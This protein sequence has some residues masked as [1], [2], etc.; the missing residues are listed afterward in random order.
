FASYDKFFL[1]GDSITQESY[2]QQWGFGFSAALQNAYIRRL[3]VVNRGLSGYNTRQALKVLPSIIPPPGQARIRFLVVFFGANDASVPWGDNKQHIPLDEY[4]DNLKNIITH[5]QVAAHNARIILV[6]PPPVNEHR[7]DPVNRLASD[8][9]KYAEAACEVGQEL[10][11]SVVNLWKAF[12]ERTGW[13]ADKWKAD[14]PIPGSLKLAENDA[15]LELMWDA[16]LH[17]YPAGYEVLFQETIKLITEKWPD[18]LPENLPMILPLWS[19]PTAW[20]AWEKS[21]K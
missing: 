4:K 6:T 3:D 7:F 2:S 10:G 21:T 5:P 1:F 8:T 14:E 13:E 12:M 15:L 17:F 20:E 16:G 19:D 9:K 11:V 18:Q